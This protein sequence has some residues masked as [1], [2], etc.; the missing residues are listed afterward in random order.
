MYIFP[1]DELLDTL[2]DKFFD[3]IQ[4]DKIYQT[5]LRDKNFV[6][7]QP[8]IISFIEDFY[9]ENQQIIK[10]KKEDIQKII[11]DYLKTY[12]YYYFFIGLTYHYQGGRD[13]FITNMVEISKN[14]SKSKVKILDFFNSD[15]NGSIIKFFT[16]IKNILEL[17]P[18]KT[19]EK[20]KI[21]LINAP[22]KFQTTLEFINYFGEEFILKRVIENTD[23]FHI[24]I[25]SI[26]I[27]EIYFKKD[28]ENLIKIVE[29]EKEAEGEFTYITIVTSLTGKM[30]DFNT[31]EKLLTPQQIREGLADDIY[32]YIL[33]Y[34]ER[35]KQYNL[36]KDKNIDYL[37]TNKILIPITEDFLRFHKNT[38]KYQSGEKATKEDTKAKYI[39]S[40]L[41]QVK[42]YYSPNLENNPKLKLNIKNLFFN[43]M[44]DKLATLVNIQEDVKIK[45]KLILADTSQTEEIL[46]DMENL[47]RYSYLNFNHF[48]KDGFKIRPSMSVEGVRYVSLKREFGNKFVETRMA[49][50]LIDINVVGV[51]FNH[52]KLIPKMILT[53]NLINQGTYQDFL[54]KVLI[55]KSKE[56]S[57][58]LFDTNKDELKTELYEDVA[59]GDKDRT[60]KV[61][62]QDF[63]YQYYNFLLN[64]IKDEI[65]NKKIINQFE[66]FNLLDKYAKNYVDFFREPELYNEIFNFFNLQ[67]IKNIKITEDPVDNIIP[68]K[69]TKYKLPIYKVPKPKATTILVE[70]TKKINLEE[71]LS[72]KSL[73]IHHLIWE[74]IRVMNKKEID[75]FNQK[76]FDFV[77]QYVRENKNG[78]YICKSCNELI[79][80]EKYQI[81]GTYVEEVDM[82]MTTAVGISQPLESL[83]KYKN[84]TRTIRNLDRVIEN[85]SFSSNIKI[86]LG[87]D[88][89]IRL[90]RRLMT[91]DIIDLVQLH[92]QYIKETIK[93]RP[94]DFQ[95]RY[96]ISPALSNLFFFELKDDI[97]LTSSKDTDKFKIIKY[98][99]LMTYMLLLMIL[100]LSS[101][102]LLDF[103][104]NKFVNYYLYEKFMSVFEKLKL[105]ISQNE[106]IT[107]S[108]IPLLCYAIY[109]LS[110]LLV[111]QDIWLYPPSED[112]K[113]LFD[114]EVQKEV[115]HTLLDLI[116]SLVESNF[117]ENKNIL[118]EIIITR[119]ISK[120]RRTYQDTKMFERIKQEKSQFISFDSNTKKMKFIEKKVPAIDLNLAQEIELKQKEYNQCY[121]SKTK[122]DKNELNFVIYQLT[123]EKLNEVTNKQIKRILKK[124][125]GDSN[126]ASNPIVK[127][128]CDKYGPNFELDVD[129]KDIQII[130]DTVAKEDQKKQLTLELQV[131]KDKEKED[132]KQKR[133][134]EVLSSFEKYIN[135]DS[136][137]DFIKSLSSVLGSKVKTEKLELYLNDDIIIVNHDY[138][139]NE[140][141]EKLSFLR[142]SGLLKEE[143]KNS[144]FNQDVLYFFDNKSKLYLYYDK[145]ELQYLGY[146]SDKKKYQKMFSRNNLEIKY[147]V[148]NMLLNLGSRNLYENI[149]FYFS[150]KPKKNNEIITKL[151]NERIIRLRNLIVK[152]NSIIYQIKYKNL[153]LQ[154]LNTKE[155]L[156]VD[157]FNNRISDFNIKDESGKNS[158]FKN[159]KYLSY[160][161]P[162]KI[163]ENI[164]ISHPNYL[165]VNLLNKLKN[166]DMKLINFLVYHLNNL[167][168]YNS[169]KRIQNE[170]AYLVV[171]LIKFLF[172]YYYQE[173]NNLEIRKFN[174]LINSDEPVLDPSYKIIGMYQEIIKNEELESEEY[175][176]KQ[177]DAQEE[178]D[179]IDYDDMEDEY[180]EPVFEFGGYDDALE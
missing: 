172:D 81:A 30:V 99:N 163:T 46:N 111:Q 75:K 6:R 94:R 173:M 167:I 171:S 133:V 112:K 60:I 121:I 25:K 91:K 122:L 10:D 125:C 78:D 22:I 103:K 175:Q 127:K 87:N 23:N 102:Q 89:V 26:V 4:K 76:V 115:I 124:I 93:E 179:A 138:L 92:T 64:Q 150:E 146:S 149:N 153:T 77:K 58:W 157:E 36:E 164:L 71:I 162:D 73:C 148:R 21:A 117:R 143:D 142:S 3:K 128:I 116:N 28:R 41:N 39:I 68:G 104:E 84:L 40:K 97:F 35:I 66:L 65:K 141:K 52:Q 55:D 113:K 109:Y 15:A 176:E 7:F 132:R 12:L 139:G 79:P 147:S 2:L 43:P 98:N 13:T 57:Y 11:N 74:D 177:L 53:K 29:Q 126:I 33:D 137:N 17:V 56:I 134:K 20:I 48:S 32:S 144:F 152:S 129:E 123:K 151:L 161:Q 47:M 88:P 118:N 82:F 166:L 168:K 95:T 16:I 180:D 159:W 45:S 107:L 119:F 85:L 101:G 83:P 31:I 8:N 19:L 9:K 140:R 72:Y 42:N 105:R 70:K 135:Q 114:F 165:D 169:N 160:L 106:M 170:I 63:Y 178:A 96:G 38:E 131:K 44:M 120:L 67:M 27:K 14:Q 155:K 1:V 145:Y 51:I 18:L 86:F 136:I 62:L 108:K 100:E 174:I 59:G 90:R 80:L 110:G 69:T 158:V 37:L 49:N 50:D 5:V 130:K 61:F 34:K 24:L 154:T 156:L 54:K